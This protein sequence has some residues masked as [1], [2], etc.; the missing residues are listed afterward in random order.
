MSPVKGVFGLQPNN[1]N[2]NTCNYDDKMKH[3]HNSH[4]DRNQT[5]T[6]LSNHSK[7]VWNSAFSVSLPSVKT[8]MERTY[9]I[10]QYKFFG[11]WGANGM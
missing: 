11:G 5:V 7:G 3:C 9:D 10:I 4:S 1:K 6:S 2:D 8:W